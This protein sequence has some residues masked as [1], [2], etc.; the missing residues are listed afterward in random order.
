MDDACCNCRCGVEVTD[1][2]WE[3]HRYPPVVHPD[4]P[5]VIK[6]PINLPE[7][8]Q[9]EPTRVVQVGAD[10]E[11]YRADAGWPRVTPDSWCG[12]HRYVKR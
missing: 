7:E 5:W 8:I 10:G 6:D 4:A 1:G 9:I 12:E 3:C 2:V 11:L